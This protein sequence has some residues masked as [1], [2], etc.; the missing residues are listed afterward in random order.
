ML[1][2][3]PQSRSFLAVEPIDGRKGSDRLAAVCRPVL[4]DNPLGGG[5]YVLRNRSGTT[6]KRWA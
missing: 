2:L 3:P 6:L 5:V 1:Q 4:G